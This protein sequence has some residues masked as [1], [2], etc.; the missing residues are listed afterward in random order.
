LLRRGVY[1]D[2]PSVF[3]AQPITSAQYR[4][5]RQIQEE[6]GS[7]S[8]DITQPSA[9]SLVVRPEQTVNSGLFGPLPGRQDFD[10]A[11]QG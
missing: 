8:P 4:G 7:A 11:D 1:A 9:L 2:D 5:S 10:C 6:R 3:E